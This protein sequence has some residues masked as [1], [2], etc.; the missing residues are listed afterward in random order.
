MTNSV[1][2]PDIFLFVVPSL[3]REI[4]CSSPCGLINIPEESIKRDQ[5]PVKDGVLDVSR[6]SWQPW[7]F[8]AAGFEGPW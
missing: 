6:R 3:L 2:S 5:Q 4:S 1:I 8:L 7:L